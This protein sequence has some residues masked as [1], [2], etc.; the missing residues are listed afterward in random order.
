MC[1]SGRASALVGLTNINPE[2]AEMELRQARQEALAAT[3]PFARFTSDQRR[4]LIGYMSHY[5]LPIPHLLMQQGELGESLWILM[6][7]SQA[8]LHA[9]ERGQALQPVRIYGPNFFSEL[10]LKVEHPLDSTVEA[11]A[12]SQWLRLHHGDFRAFLADAGPHLLSRLELGPAEE[13][14]LGH[15][16]ARRRYGWLGAGE[17]LVI[18]QRRHIIALLRK[19]SISFVL[20]GILGLF[21]VIFLRRASGEPWQIMLLATFGLLAVLQF[22]WAVLDYLN[23]YIL[24]TNQRIVHQEKLLFFAEW[25]QAAFLEQVRNV[26]VKVTFFGNLL[27]YGNLRIQTAATAGSIGFDYVPNAHNIRAKI[28]EQ[29][30]LRQQHYQASSKMIIQNLLEERLGLRLEMPVRVTAGR[31]ERA[32]GPDWLR[33]V[34]SWLKLD[35]PSQPFLAD[36][37]VWRKHWLILLGKISG[38]AIILA[39]ILLLVS[40]QGLLPA[41]VGVLVAALDMGLAFIGLGTMAW[42]AWNVADWRNDTYEIDNKQIADVAKKPLFFAENRRTALLGEI[43]NIE[44]RMPSP[45]NFLFNFGDVRLQTAATE[46]L[47]T[48]DW[49][50]N[51]RAVSEEIRRRIEVYRQQQETTRMRQRAEEMPDWFEIYDRLE[52]NG[53]GAENSGKGRP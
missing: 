47:F 52:G 33:R 44:V 16:R 14:F 21:A 5:Y 20:V 42:L 9:L 43:E 50:P 19:A 29:Q 41:S 22:V 4:R 6:P 27:N 53:D 13:R 48:F 34:R 3:A 37:L 46:G 35:R 28:L 10:A 18:F 49:V 36:H 32:Q 23:D 17:N 40:L 45:I 8:I 12:G 30:S 15:N 7:H 25:R 1:S 26:D 31:A 51:P 39:F 38:P 24:V 2:K 11:E